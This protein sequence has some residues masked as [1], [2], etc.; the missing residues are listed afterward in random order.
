[1]LVFYR[2]EACPFI[3]RLSQILE[4]PAMVERLRSLIETSSVA[5]L[6]EPWSSI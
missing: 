4:L 1:L 2:R 5:C 6:A 3:Q